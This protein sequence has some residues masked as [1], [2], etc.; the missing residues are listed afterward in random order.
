MSRT[1]AYL[2]LGSNLGDRTAHLTGAVRAL[3]AEDPGLRVSSLYESP[4]MGGPPGQGAFLNC[5]VE[6]HTA[7]SPR[8]LLAL[9]HRLESEAKRVRTVRNGPRTLDVDVLLYGDLSITEEDLVIPHPRMA[10]R[11][12]VLAPL[13]ELASRL[14]P[15]AW[16][17][18]IAPDVVGD[19]RIVG[20]IPPG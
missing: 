4:P 14:V 18:R 16:R 11:P 5:V 15:P 13:E 2:G 17:E 20:T 9:A 6:L 7:R 1:T 8:D 19:L 10:E 3:R 12:F